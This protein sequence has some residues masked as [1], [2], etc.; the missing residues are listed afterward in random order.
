MRAQLYIT[1]LASERKQKNSF[2]VLDHKMQASATEH[3]ETEIFIWRWK[4]N[5][6]IILYKA[7]SK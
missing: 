6:T 3:F 7:K 5:T 2:S 4:Q 1:V